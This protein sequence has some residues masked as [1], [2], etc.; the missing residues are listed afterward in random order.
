LKGVKDA[1][2]RERVRKQLIKILENPEVGKPL[3]YGLRGERTVSVKP[4]RPIYS[5]AGDRLVLL[6]FEHRKRVH[7]R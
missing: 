2:L 1:G 5:V 7:K 3:R 4:W 6:R